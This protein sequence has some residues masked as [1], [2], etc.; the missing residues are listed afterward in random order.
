MALA[1]GV[2]I[3]VAIAWIAMFM[4]TGRQW[5]GPAATTDVGLVKTTDGGTIWHLE[6][7]DNAWHHV[8]QYWRMQISGMSLMIPIEDYEDRRCDLDSLPAHM[9]PASVD[10]LIMMAWYHETGFPFGALTCAVHWETQVRNADIIYTVEGGVQ[11][12]RDANFNPRA[13]PLIPVWPGFILD[14]LA[15][16]AA[17]LLASW[18]ARSAGALVRDR[19]GRCPQCG[20][21]RTGLPADS[22]CP[23]CGTARPPDLTTPSREN[24]R[25]P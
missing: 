15:W 20:Y 6:R 8:V 1:V 17:W 5:Y 24:N 21:L 10:E 4:P 2:M 9:R 16:G 14:V 22:A 18:L 11:F 12:S 23:E 25:A 13:L 3:T 19:R 7:G